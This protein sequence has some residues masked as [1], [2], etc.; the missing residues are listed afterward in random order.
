[1][2]DL[3]ITIRDFRE[4]R[5]WPRARHWFEKNGLDWRD[6]VRNGIPVSNLRAIDDQ[7]TNVDRVEA[8][9]RRRLNGR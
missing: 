9:A 3:I 8:A 7:Q 6:F 4:A 1:M 5:I 2:S